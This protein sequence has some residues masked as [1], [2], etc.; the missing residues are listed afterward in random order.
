MGRV[1]RTAQNT[2]KGQACRENE[3]MPLILR[4]LTL[5]LKSFYELGFFQ[6]WERRDRWGSGGGGRREEYSIIGLCSSGS[7]MMKLLV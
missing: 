2:L 3:V 7:I 5:R 6:S 1:E 4:E